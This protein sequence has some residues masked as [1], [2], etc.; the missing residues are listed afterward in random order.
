[1]ILASHRPCSNTIRQFSI[2]C[3]ILLAYFLMKSSGKCCAPP[4]EPPRVPIRSSQTETSLPSPFMLNTPWNGCR[5]MRL[6][7]GP[8]S[9]FCKYLH[10][11]TH[12]IIIIFFLRF[13]HSRSHSEMC[14]CCYVTV[15]EHRDVCPFI[16]AKLCEG[17]SVGG[18]ESFSGLTRRSAKKSLHQ[19]C[20]FKKE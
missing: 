3:H 2:L 8:D 17:F 13:P 9:K 5:W 10:R 12:N 11:A 4:T 15:N 1:M 14:R 6:G 18:V 7:V 20:I 19:K 16:Y